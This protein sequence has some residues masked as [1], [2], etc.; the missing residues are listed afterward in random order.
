[1]FFSNLSL[2]VT[3][4]T[5][6]KHQWHSIVRSMSPKL[7]HMVVNATWNTINECQ[8]HIQQ[9]NENEFTT[10]M[11]GHDKWNTT[12]QGQCHMEYNTLRSMS[13]RIQYIEVNV[14]WNS[15]Y[16]GQCHVEY[17]ISRSMSYRIQH[18]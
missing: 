18:I 4:I 17:N 8:G 3:R 2:N 6:Y 12:Y 15:T 14:M 13:C 5:T 1:M 11:M 9:H 16:Q 10:Y 7:L